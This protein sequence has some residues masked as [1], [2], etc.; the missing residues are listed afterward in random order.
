MIERP[1]KNEY[2]INIAKEIASRSTCVRAHH[3]VVIV[4]DDQII[5]TWYNWAPRNT[6]DCIQ[7]NNCLRNILNIPSWERY[8]L[9]RSI[10]AEQNSIINAARAWV[11]LFW[12][13]M[14][15]YSL[16]INQNNEYEKINS[17]PCFICKKMI[18]NA[19]ITE[20]ISAQKDWTIKIFYIKDWIEE[21]Q[22]KDLI[23]D[24]DKY[25]TITI[26]KK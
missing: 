25:W 2:Y 10:H 24:A 19:W 15:I 21:W 8:E 17:L 6:K 16:R 13:K 11:S 5:S 4:R 3:W 7:R 14:Y 12:W 23:D 9:C 18:V 20:F 26:N 22:E 1:S